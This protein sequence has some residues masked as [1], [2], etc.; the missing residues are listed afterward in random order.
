MSFFVWFS[1]QYGLHVVSA[2]MQID[3]Q[4]DE[5][6]FALIRLRFHPSHC[7]QRGLWGRSGAYSIKVASSI[8]FCFL[9]AFCT[10]ERA[11]DSCLTRIILMAAMNGVDAKASESQPHELNGD[12]EDAIESDVQNLLEEMATTFK[13]FSE[14]VFAKG[15]FVFPG[16]V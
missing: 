8:S 11:G 14:T 5:G 12:D 15:A 13:S 1:T 4:S 10:Q 2:I 16:A 7:L 9:P 6:K 3:N